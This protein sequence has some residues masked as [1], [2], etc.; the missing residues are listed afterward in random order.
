VPLIGEDREKPGTNRARGLQARRL[1]GSGCRVSASATQGGLALA[2]LQ[3]LPETALCTGKTRQ[4]ARQSCSLSRPA[5]KSRAI[6]WPEADLQPAID[7][8]EQ[9][10]G[11]RSSEIGPSVAWQ[12]EQ[13]D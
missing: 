5:R 12:T 13:R 1:G 4:L 10:V 2:G 6:L 9:F 7:P 3:R 11:Q 8:I